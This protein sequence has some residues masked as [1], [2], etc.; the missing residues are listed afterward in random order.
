M[1]EDEFIDKLKQLTNTQFELNGK[2]F[3]DSKKKI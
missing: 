2:L 3:P 1:T